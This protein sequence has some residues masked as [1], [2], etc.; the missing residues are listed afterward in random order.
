MTTLFIV[1]LLGTTAMAQLDKP[2][3]Q[4]R[5]TVMHIHGHK[6]FSCA[7]EASKTIY[8]DANFTADDALQDYL[9]CSSRL[10]E[11]AVSP[12][13]SIWN[14][15]HIDGAFFGSTVSQISCMVEKALEEREI[16]MVFIYTLGDQ[17]YTLKTTR[18]GQDL[19]FYL[20]TKEGAP[21]GPADTRRYVIHAKDGH[22][23]SWHN[24]LRST[25][26]KPFDYQEPAEIMMHQET[27][28]AVV[29]FVHAFLV[30]KLCEWYFT[31]YT[32]RLVAWYLL[33]NWIW[34]TKY[35]FYATLSY[36]FPQSRFSFYCLELISGDIDIVGYIKRQVFIYMFLFSSFVF[37]LSVLFVFS[38]FFFGYFFGRRQRAAFSRKQHVA[39]IFPRLPAYPNRVDQDNITPDD[40]YDAVIGAFEAE[41]AHHVSPNTPCSACVNGTCDNQL[42]TIIY[43]GVVLCPAAQENLARKPNIILNAVGSKVHVDCVTSRGVK[44]T[45]PVV[46]HAGRR[47]NIRGAR[48]EF[49]GKGCPISVY[50]VYTTPDPVLQAKVYNSKNVGGSIFLMDASLIT[51]ISPSRETVPRSVF[52][53]IATRL[54]TGQFDEARTFE[55][56]R[57]FLASK[58]LSLGIEL[59]HYEQWLILL[60]DQVGRTSTNVGPS[61]LPFLRFGAPWYERLWYHFMQFIWRYDGFNSLPSNEN[62]TFTNIPVPAYEVIVDPGLAERNEPRV[63]E[64]QNPFQDDRPAADAPIGEEPQ[65]DARPDGH[66]HI[67][68]HR[69]E[70]NRAPAHPQ[71]ADHRPAPIPPEGDNVV[72]HPPN[73]P[74]VPPEANHVPDPPR[75]GRDPHAILADRTDRLPG[76]V[77]GLDRR[78]V[79]SSTDGGDCVLF[80]VPV[81]VPG[82]FGDIDG[83]RILLWGDRAAA[84]MPILSC[85]A[86][87]RDRL[88]RSIAE[89]ERSP[90][91]IVAR[92]CGMHSEN[93][94]CAENARRIPPTLACARAREEIRL[95]EENDEDRRDA[96]IHPNPNVGQEIPPRAPGPAPAG[97]GRGQANGRRGPQGR[98]RQ[99]LFENGNLHNVDRPAQHLAQNRQAPQRPGPAR[100]RN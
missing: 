25:E 48:L 79:T 58:L 24:G 62:W 31:T 60:H 69:D 30:W 89:G 53:S 52:T 36:F 99:V 96:D 98:D 94:R 22:A 2:M 16:D 35:I 49:G 11:A 83:Y 10:G 23:V 81:S 3:Y 21:S 93:N 66:E 77:F 17:H 29:L 70:G 42:L 97:R 100:L 56:C 92:V 39:R 5:E 64:A 38:R 6:V 1:A 45:R 34:L 59:E 32:K 26:I 74:G 51:M 18:F 12:L 68:V 84:P 95:Q 65:R 90:Y 20:R 44:S 13:P 50:H 55:Q 72:L 82:R 57:T 7:L 91:E 37:F 8:L 85:Y 47:H 33:L 43:P 9:F 63:P 27:L 15:M 88:R 67:D 19:Q 14:N 87:S 86:C 46:E 76:A 75:V 40:S 4:Q 28:G 78:R 73:N 41:L 54:C 61:L 80:H 71:P